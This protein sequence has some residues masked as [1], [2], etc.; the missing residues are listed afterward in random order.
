[1]KK[2]RIT[3]VP[4]E[5]LAVLAAQAGR[6]A[7]ERARKA[8]LPITGTEDGKIVKTFPDGRKVILKVLD[9]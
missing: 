3:E 6:G 4:L 2:R 9:D 1:M 8:G 7:V 5:E